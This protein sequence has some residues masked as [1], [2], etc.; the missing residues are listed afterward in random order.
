MGLDHRLV[1]ARVPMRLQITAS[2]AVGRTNTPRS[3]LDGQGCTGLPVD[4][5]MVKANK[6][7]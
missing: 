6:S 2:G 3:G 4:Q 5:T 7:M 1:Q